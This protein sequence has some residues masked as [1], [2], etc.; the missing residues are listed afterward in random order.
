MI[1]DMGSILLEEEEEEIDVLFEVS[2]ET[3][4]VSGRETVRSGLVRSQL[5]A[6]S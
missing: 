4:T 6:A 3:G 5:I 1:S 2:E